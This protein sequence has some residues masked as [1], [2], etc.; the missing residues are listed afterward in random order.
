VRNYIDLVEKTLRVLH[1]LGDGAVTL[2][3]LAARTGLLK[4]SAFRILDTLKEPGYV[5]RPA[6]NGIYRVT[7]KVLE[8]SR[9]A[10]GRPSL[11]TLARPHL[12]RLTKVTTRG[13]VAQAAGLPT[14]SGRIRDPAPPRTGPQVRQ[15]NLTGGV[16]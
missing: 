11:L 8:L 5:E 10:S 2:K 7:C 9:G 4:S 1:A 14:E 13:R 6:C 3:D 16:S 12:K 15:S